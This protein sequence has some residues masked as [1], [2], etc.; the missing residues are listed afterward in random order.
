L[1]QQLLI[2]IGVD[3]AAELPELSG[4]DDMYADSKPAIYNSPLGKHTLKISSRLFGVVG[5]QQAEW[6]SLLR[7]AGPLQG[8]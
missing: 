8:H 1:A 6:Q 2:S 7:I 4:L 5:R 3:P